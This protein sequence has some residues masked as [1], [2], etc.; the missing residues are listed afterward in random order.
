[1]YNVPSGASTSPGSF[2]VVP[3]VTIVELT[4]TGTVVDV[5]T[6]EGDALV[7]EPPGDVDATPPPAGVPVPSA[8]VPPEPTAAPPS[9]PA[10]MADASMSSVAV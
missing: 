4:V 9:H 7:T 8:G 10:K 1:M 6:G 2:P 5:A 3:T